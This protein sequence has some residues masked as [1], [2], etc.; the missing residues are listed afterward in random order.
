MTGVVFTDTLRRNWRTGLYWTIGIALLGVYIIAVIP[1]V[2]M[3]NQ[4][5]TLVQ[6]MPPPFNL[7][8]IVSPGAMYTVFLFNLTLAYVGL[9]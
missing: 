3:L 7:S 6:T 8:C 1:N 5:A 2:D 9:P 4:Y